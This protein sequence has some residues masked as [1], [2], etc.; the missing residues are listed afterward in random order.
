MKKQLYYIGTDPDFIKDMKN[1]ILEKNVQVEFLESQDTPIAVCENSIPAVVYVDFTGT[2]DED[3]LI[4]QVTYLKKIPCY[5]TVLFVALLSDE[6]HLSDLD[7]IF[8]SGFQLSFIKGGEVPSLFRDSFYIATNEVLSYPSY[9]LAQGLYRKITTS[10][11]STITS[12]EANGFT[13][14]TDFESNASN[15]SFSQ[16]IFPELVTAE[17]TAG[18]SQASRYSLTKSYQ[19]MFPMTDPWAESTAFSLLPETI[20]TWLDLH[21][22]Q[23]TVKKDSV[24]VIEAS[25]EFLRAG[26]DV[27]YN[28]QFASLYFQSLEECSSMIDNVRPPLIFIEINET[29][30]HPNSIQRLERFVAEIRKIK[31]YNPILILTNM[32]SSTV[33]VQKLISYESILCSLNRMQGSLICKFAELY[34]NKKLSLKED[35]SY[36]FSSSSKMRTIDINFGIVVNKITEHEIFFRCEENLPMNTVLHFHEPMEFYATIIPSFV[37]N[38]VEIENKMKIALIHGVSEE[39]LEGLRQLVNLL[40]VNPN[41]EFKISEDHFGSEILENKTEELGKEKL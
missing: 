33:A 28:T 10:I 21:N 40:I 19:L 13:V 24:F 22:D 20:E 39:K 25:S 30:N 31:A 34:S 9:A 5:K 36:L 16:K 27:E 7:Y 26:F 2:L 35:T 18:P 29:D 8:T 6:Q 14:E 23:F 15:L 12:I 38:A 37:E 1:Y 11:C 32:P 4:R 17:V 3:L 41:T